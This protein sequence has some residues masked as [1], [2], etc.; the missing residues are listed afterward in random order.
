MAVR[1]EPTAWIGWNIFAGLMMIIVAGFNII[2][3]LVALL[4][5]EHFVP[6]RAGLLIF[7]FTTWGWILLAIG[8]V[9]LFAASAILSGK[10]W[11]RMVGIL[12]VALNAW[13][14]LTLLDTQP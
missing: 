4:D 8:V 5:K 9:Q 13:G 12:F 1:R 2:Y 6:T 14:H 10:L 11:G 3:A 7:D